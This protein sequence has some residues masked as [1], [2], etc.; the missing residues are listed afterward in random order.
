[1]HWQPNNRYT[2]AHIIWLSDL[3][4]LSVY[5]SRAHISLSYIPP[6]ISRNE[7]KK[8][9]GALNAQTRKIQSSAEIIM[10]NEIVWYFI[11]KKHNEFVYS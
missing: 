9:R 1:M 10:I 8:I 6:L 5:V 4:S 2:H 7:T 3:N 11:Y